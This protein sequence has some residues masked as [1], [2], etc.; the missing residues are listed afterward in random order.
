[1]SIPHAD[2]AV[3]KHTAAALANNYAKTH[4]HAR[5]TFDFAPA[6]KNCVRLDDI[7]RVGKI[8]SPS[9]SG[10]FPEPSPR[11]TVRISATFRANHATGFTGGI[12]ISRRAFARAHDGDFF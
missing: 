8:K 6:R 1:M 10:I 12:P 7:I 4:D 9:P 5:G 3:P 11:S 2:T